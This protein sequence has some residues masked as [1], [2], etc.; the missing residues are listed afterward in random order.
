[1]ADALSRYCGWHNK[2]F[3]LLFAAKSTADMMYGLQNLMWP[4]CTTHPLEGHGKRPIGS[5][6][7]CLCLSLS[8]NKLCFWFTWYG[9]PPIWDGTLSQF[10]YWFSISFNAA[11][12]CGVTDFSINNWMPYYH[13]LHTAKS[14]YISD[15]RLQAE[16]WW[17]NHYDFLRRPNLCK[18]KKS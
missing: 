4:T 14:K 1:M 17:Y 2:V 12:R 8:R 13:R 18:L 7:L 6:A 15:L 3:N 10:I 11:A 9:Y 5:Q 16:V